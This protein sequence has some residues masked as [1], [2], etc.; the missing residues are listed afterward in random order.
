M[1]VPTHT[2]IY[3]YTLL[4]EAN[5]NAYCFYT[6]V[7]DSVLAQPTLNSS[8]KKWTEYKTVLQP[9]MQAV[10]VQVMQIILHCK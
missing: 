4:Q 3:M 5:N 9:T 10:K 7:W 1:H 2:R 8:G 6:Q